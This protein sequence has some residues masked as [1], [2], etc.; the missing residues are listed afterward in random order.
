MERERDRER[1]RQ[2]ETDIQ[3]ERERE[4]ESQRDKETRRVRGL[5]PT[6]GL[7]S[8]AS[9]MMGLS[10]S[11]SSLKTRALVRPRP[12][13]RDSVMSMLSERIM[14]TTCLNREEGDGVPMIYTHTHRSVSQLSR[15]HTRQKA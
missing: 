5:C 7:L 10:S 3:T 14:G 13:T 4:T 9:L 2:R 15:R 11:M 8:R 12:S 6:S 1:E